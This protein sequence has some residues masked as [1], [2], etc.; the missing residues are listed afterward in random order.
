MLTDN[1]AVLAYVFGIPLFLILV[2]VI[3]GW[4]KSIRKTKN[5]GVEY[6]YKGG[7]LSGG[8]KGSGPDRFE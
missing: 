2:A 7:K 3:M 6:L 8:R 1:A 5:D 4:I